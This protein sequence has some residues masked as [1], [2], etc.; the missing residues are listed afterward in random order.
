MKFSKHTI[1]LCAV[2]IIGIILRCQNFWLPPVDAHPMRQT[3]TESVAYYFARFD[4]N[5]LHPQASLI[6]PVSN[7][8][9]YFFLEFPAYQYILAI[10]YKIFG[11][12]IAVARIYNLVLFSISFWL[13]YKVSKQMFEKQIAFWATIIFTLIP[14]SLFFFGHAIHPDLFAVTCVLG[15]LYLV[16]MSPN[17]KWKTILAGLFIGIAVGTR[18][19]ILMALPSI[20]LMIFFRKGK[21]WE[22]VWISISSVLIYFLW[23]RWQLYFPE[24][25]HSWQYWTLYGQELLLTFAGWKFLI[26]RNVSGEVVGRIASVLAAVG[27]MGLILKLKN[28]KQLILNIFKAPEKI[29]TDLKILLFCTPWLLAVPVYW[30]IAP[31]GNTYHQ[32]Y[33]NV[34]VYPIILLAAYGVMFISKRLPTRVPSQLLAGMLIFFA[35][36]YNGIRT[37]NHFYSDIVPEHFLRIAE[38]INKAIPEGERIVYLAYDNSVP[39]SLAHRQGWMLGYSLIDVTNTDEAVV[40]MKK[41]GL[42]NYAIYAPSN[43]DFKGEELRRLRDHAY[44]DYKSELIEVYR[45]H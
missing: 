8:Y 15:C 28:I 32:Y 34:F 6:R 21:W 9:G 42:A 16:T 22:I 25:D 10:F 39:M 31:I 33:A 40:E 19:F 17:K 7:K 38:E 4:M 2:W 35:L 26:W 11:F 23:T 44:L 5:P 43:N 14:S 45:F 36:L 20:I 27:S 18:P 1:V 29:S 37:S 24:A 41:K 30:F 13:V 3:D 12:S